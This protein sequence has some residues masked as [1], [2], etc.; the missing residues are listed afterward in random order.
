[1]DKVDVIVHRVNEVFVQLECDDSIKA[2]L[3]DFFSFYAPN[4]Q[5]SP[6]YK[7]K[8]WN[9]KIYL[10]SKKTSRIY[11]GLIRYIKDFCEE[12]KLKCLVDPAAH[13]FNE[14]S[15]EEAVAF[16]QSLDLHS[17]GQAIEPRDYQ[18]IGFVKAIKYRKALLL[19]PTA[20][21]KSL[22]K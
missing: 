21:G 2:E 17:R 20:S 12:R 19:S 9:G 4:Y 22:I 8:I 5:F 6:L 13:V 15:P 11:G 3:N 10:Y 1:M 14:F 16:A 18:F 7:K